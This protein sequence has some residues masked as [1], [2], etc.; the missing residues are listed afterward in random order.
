MPIAVIPPL[1]FFASSQTPLRV[2][3]PQL[4]TSSIS[5][6]MPLRCIAQ[7]ASGTHLNESNHVMQSSTTQQAISQ[8]PLHVFSEGER[9]DAFVP[10]ADADDGKK[11]RVLKTGNNIITSRRVNVSVQHEKDETNRSVV[12]FSSNVPHAVLHHHRHS[13]TQQKP[14]FTVDDD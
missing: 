9:T 5:N 12:I 11:G 7:S 13:S 2:S 10:H 1:M 8:S 3:E 14:P 6:F 4:T